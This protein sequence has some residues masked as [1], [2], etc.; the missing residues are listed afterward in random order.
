MPISLEK[1]ERDAPRLIDL[2][3]KADIS[4]L[5][6]NLTNHQA[7]V[8]LCLDISGSMSF[9]YSSGKIQ[10]LAEK[11]LA[12]GCRFDD[13][14][15][16]D[17]FLFGQNP[18]QVGEMTL[19]NFQ[20]F[21]P[22]IEQEHP[23]ETGTY[24]GKVMKMIRNFYFPEGNGDSRNSPFT[25]D[26]PIYV[27]FVTD[28]ATSDEEETQ[29]QLKWSSFEPIFWQFM[30]IGKPR[31]DVS[32]EGLS[33]FVGK[34]LA[35]DFSFLEKLDEMKGYTDNAAF[36]N[37]EDPESISDDELYDILMEEYPSWVKFAYSKQLLK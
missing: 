36:F 2:A 7:K 33:G 4:I 27:M 28:G 8:A 5:K 24:Y 18:H 30:A 11:I 12:L 25:A 34:A 23:L 32:G 13:N 35:T 1:I 10:T 37:V 16:I 19:G 20:D 15:S 9:L 21:I 29:N 17:I 26:E 6:A 3:K 22:N 14:G 31:K